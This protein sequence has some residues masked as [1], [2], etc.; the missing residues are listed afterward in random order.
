MR[1]YEQVG[2]VRELAPRRRH[3][4]FKARRGLGL[5]GRE[6]EQRPLTARGYRQG[7]SV[8]PVLERLDASEKLLHA[9]GVG[10]VHNLDLVARRSRRC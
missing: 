9:R 1:D 7:N 6:G 8:T 5:V 4:R 10:N 3:I 2:P